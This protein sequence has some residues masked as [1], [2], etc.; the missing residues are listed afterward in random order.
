MRLLVLTP[1]C[2][3]GQV[4]DLAKL[5]GLHSMA[6]LNCSLL[7]PSEYGSM[8][9]SS[10]YLAFGGSKPHPQQTISHFSV[11]RC[12]P[13]RHGTWTRRV[14][15][16][17]RRRA[18]RGRSR[19]RIGADRGIGAVVGVV[20]RHLPVQVV[21]EAGILASRRSSASSLRLRPS[22]GTRRGIGRLSCGLSP[23]TACR[24]Y[25]PQ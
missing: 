12:L 14:C 6:R 20:P 15:Y 25:G 3:E 2:R 23:P 7:P 24:G 1:Q 11:R 5:H 13:F 19:L 8:W 9:S 10:R 4:L 22:C 16:A 18:R 17:S 21:I